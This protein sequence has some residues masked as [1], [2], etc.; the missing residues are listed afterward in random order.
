[1]ADDQQNPRDK[2]NIGHR[3]GEPARRPL[4]VLHEGGAK[5][6]PN[7]NGNKEQDQGE[8]PTFRQ[9]AAKQTVNKKWQRQNNRKIAQVTFTEDNVLEGAEISQPGS[10]E[11]KDFFASLQRSVKIAGQQFLQDQA[12]DPVIKDSIITAIEW[13][14]ATEK[15]CIV[16]SDN[17]CRQR[18]DDGWHDHSLYAHSHEDR[19]QSGR[20]RQ[21][22]YATRN[23][24]QTNGPWR[25]QMHGKRVRFDTAAEY[26]FSDI[27]RLHSS[28]SVAGHRSEVLALAFPHNRATPAEFAADICRR[29]TDHFEPRHGE[30]PAMPPHPETPVACG[31]F[32]VVIRRPTVA[33]LVDKAGPQPNRI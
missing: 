28:A 10:T 32:H 15:T 3:V 17:Q 19:K 31:A 2:E 13:P 11:V 5:S 18:D 24:G 9:E 21:Q 4:L 6:G 7:R 12:P 20:R 16:Y 23:A 33:K 27:G 25:R 8:R 30:S 22:Q 1:A 26:A 14:N 29:Q